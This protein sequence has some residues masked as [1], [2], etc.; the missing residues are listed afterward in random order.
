MESRCWTA[1]RGAVPEVV[2]STRSIITR[3][4]TM[5]AQSVSA[6]I[7][8]EARRLD[9]IGHPVI[10]STAEPATVTDAA[11]QYRLACRHG[12]GEHALRRL[13]LA[14]A[15]GGRGVAGRIET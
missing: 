1:L 13:A 15:D 9:S 14:L 4:E 6:E 7:V 11:E 10:V 2:P 3:K 5:S 8:A 12:D